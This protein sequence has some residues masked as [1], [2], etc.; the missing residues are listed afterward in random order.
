MRY[1]VLTLLIP[2]SLFA[3]ASAPVRA[4][5][6]GNNGEPAPPPP[7]TPTA[8]LASMEGTVYNALGGTPLRK[9]TVN[10]NRQNGGPMPQGAR[11]NYSGTSDASG[12][13]AI[14]GIE[15]GTYRVNVNHTGYLGMAYNPAGRTVRA[16]RSIWGARRK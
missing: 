5:G 8:D 6:R 3:Q 1:L 12:H 10:L 14:S 7:P 4:G 11:G 2:L 15:P 9:A 13:Y 16:R